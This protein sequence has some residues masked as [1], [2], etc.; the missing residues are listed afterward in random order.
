[1]TNTRREGNTVAPTANWRSAIAAIKRRLTVRQV[2]ESLGGRVRD[3]RRAD[4]LQCKGSAKGTV[5]YKD[6]VWHCHRCLAG[7]D[8]VSLVQTV[9]RSDFPAALNW[10][11]E[12]AHVPLPTAISPEQ[13]RRSAAER[14]TYERISRAAQKLEVAENGLRVFHRDR[15][16]RSERRQREVSRRLKELGHGA[17]ERYAGETELCWWVLAALWMPLEGDLAAYTLLSFGVEF[18]RANFVLKPELRDQMV[19]AVQWNGGFYVKDD[20]NKRCW[21]EGLR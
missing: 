3:R 13:Q 19:A 4:C 5:A 18:D 11:A 2:F 21:I 10:L 1:M 20:D 8:I 6:H 9:H 16:H 17:N 12:L 14:A 15:I 7:G